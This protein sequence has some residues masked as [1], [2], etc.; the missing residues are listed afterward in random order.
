MAGKNRS[1]KPGY[2]KLMKDFFHRLTISFT[3]AW[4]GLLLAFETEQSFRIQLGVALIVLTGAFILPL[5]SFE[6]VALILASAAV[7]VL[8]L[9]NSLVERL[10]D[11]LK[12]RLNHYV[13][14]MKDLMAAA[15]LVASIFA[16]LVGFIVLWP[17][18]YKIL[19]RV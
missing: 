3:H 9:L 19:T 2:L 13:G 1:S 10:A 7:L 6:R 4:K 11:L 12:P 14:E 17:Y 15:V 16:A 18:F 5:T 8:E